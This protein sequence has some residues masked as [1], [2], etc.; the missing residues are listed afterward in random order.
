ML[1]ITHNLGVVNRIADRVCVLY[2]G[3][4]AELGAKA[5]VLGAAAHPYT[6]GLLASLP[7][8]APERRTRRL[9]PI[10]G[11][12]PDL[13]RLP[14]GCVFAPRCAFSEER[15]GEPQSLDP[16]AGD[17]KARCW[18]ARR[19]LGTPWPATTPDTHAAARI[20]SGRGQLSVERLAKTY[21]LGRSHG[22]T[23]GRRLGLPW[24]RAR[25]RILRA[26]DDVSFQ[27]ASGEVLGL[28][29]ESGSGK[30]TLARL[31]LRLIEPSAGLVRFD[32]QD[33]T[34]VPRSALT[35]FRK[36]AQ[37]VFQNPNSSLNP[38][39]TVGE[40]IA[41]AVKLH[42]D[43][44]A[45]ERRERAEALIDRVGLP[46]AY[47]DRYPHQLSG[48][49]KQRVGIARALA[50]DPAFIVCDE[51]VSALDVS[52]QATVLNLLS[53][54]KDRLGLS[55]LFISHDLSVVA[56]IADR[57][58][59]MY[60]GRLMEIGPAAAVLAPPYHPYT[61]ALLSSI[62]LPDVALAGRPRII[63]RADATGEPPLAGCPFYT[64]CPRKLGTICETATPPL[65]AAGPGHAI[66]CHIPVPDLAAVTSVLPSGGTAADLS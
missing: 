33:V 51:P 25:R 56:H 50:T 47:Y 9:V 28:V 39:R 30:S 29:G 38:R 15:C 5:S 44:P 40:A 63:V 6:K 22:V 64:R 20:P 4:V 55:Y 57:I 16:I 66:A 59:V 21:V 45:P 48:G 31:V 1:F 65:H 13:T 14:A 46:R 52:V 53:D 42:S 3:R 41:R 2:A 23:W 35:A 24:P 17:Q 19:L 37:I 26:V 7:Q 62:P 58:A 11:R 10:G 36:Q 43:C 54:L 12:F 8:L 32:A 18:K 60:A 27:I 61:E 49:E 34:G